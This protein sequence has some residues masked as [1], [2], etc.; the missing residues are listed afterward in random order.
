M[1]MFATLAVLGSS[2]WSDDSRLNPVKCMV[3]GDFDR[4]VEHE[5]KEGHDA[6]PDAVRVCHS[7]VQSCIRCD[8][9]ERGGVGEAHPVGPQVRIRGLEERLKSL[10]QG[11]ER[12]VSPMAKWGCL[13]RKKN[14]DFAECLTAV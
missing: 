12:I 7:N 9:F 10:S 3:Y 6:D 2:L 11:K 5:G 1:A 13:R 8:R 14:S 4:V